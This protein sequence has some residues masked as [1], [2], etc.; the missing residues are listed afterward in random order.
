MKFKVVLHAFYHWGRSDSIQYFLALKT[1]D[2]DLMQ[3]LL[4]VERILVHK[5]RMAEVCLMT[6]G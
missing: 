6:H 4:L 1:V 2:E 5:G 3:K